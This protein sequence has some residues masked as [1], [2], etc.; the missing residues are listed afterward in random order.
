MKTDAKKKSHT[1]SELSIIKGCL[2]RGRL[3]DHSSLLEQG[4]ATESSSQKTEERE[5]AHTLI[6]IYGK[7]GHTQ[8]GR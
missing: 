3:T 8:V 7:I 2:F 6:A 4:T 5:G 1:S